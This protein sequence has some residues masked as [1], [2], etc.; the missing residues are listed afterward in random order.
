MPRR[1]G[2]IGQEEDVEAHG[3]QFRDG[4]G[5]DWL[6]HPD[7]II[8]VTTPGGEEVEGH[9]LRPKF[10]DQEPDVEGHAG[11]VKFRDDSGQEQ[12]VEAHAMR[13]SDLRLKHS[14]E[15]LRNAL[16]RLGSI[17]IKRR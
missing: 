12:E 13:F 7:R 3:M 6:I 2:Y 17:T 8:S 15:P 10:L 5:N 16:A 9:A 14:I 11:R 4:E 1:L